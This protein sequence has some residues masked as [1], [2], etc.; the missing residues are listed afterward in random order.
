MPNDDS[1]VAAME[2]KCI[3]M[4]QLQSFMTSDMLTLMRHLDVMLKHQNST[5]PNWATRA[6][7]D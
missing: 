7:S 3:T 4:G 2:D 5:A 1:L 6:L